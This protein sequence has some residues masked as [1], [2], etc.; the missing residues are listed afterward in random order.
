VGNV[1]IIKSPQDC[2]PAGF[3]FGIAGQKRREVASSDEEML[4]Q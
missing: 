3:F 2:N 4:I 1:K